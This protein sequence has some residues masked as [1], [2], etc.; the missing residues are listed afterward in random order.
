MAHWRKRYH[1]L[2]NPTIWYSETKL[3]TPAH[4]QTYITHRNFHIFSPVSLFVFCHVAFITKIKKKNKK[5]S[6]IAG[7]FKNFTSSPTIFFLLGNQLL[8]T[9]NF[10]WLLHSSYHS[11]RKLWYNKKSFVTKN[12]TFF[13]N[14]SL[15][16]CIKVNESQCK[17]YGVTHISHNARHT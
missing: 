1:I 4:F 14:I 12:S 9:I 11:Y 7:G 16:S 2:K 13:V 10:Q 17:H 6:L 3:L 8:S 15:T 5:T